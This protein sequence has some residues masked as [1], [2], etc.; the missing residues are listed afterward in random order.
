MSKPA[1]CIKTTE[2]LMGKLILTNLTT[3]LNLTELELELEL[4]KVDMKVLISTENL[5]RFPLEYLIKVFTLVSMPL[6]IFCD[7]HMKKAL[8]M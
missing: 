1:C 7:R 3:I 6:G 2:T 4:H 5:Q 8:Y